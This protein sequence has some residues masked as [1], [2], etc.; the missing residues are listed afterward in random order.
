VMILISEW[1][2]G[3]IYKYTTLFFWCKVKKNT[4]VACMGLIREVERAS[5]GT[6]V[7]SVGRV[8]ALTD[9]RQEKRT[10]LL[11]SIRNEVRLLLREF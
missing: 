2:A 11:L 6:S 9:K 4:F 8:L 3:P 1:L 10:L 7:P 5:I